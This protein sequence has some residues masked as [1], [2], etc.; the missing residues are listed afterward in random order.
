MS[1]ESAVLAPRNRDD[2][3]EVALPAVLV[4]EGLKFLFPRLPIRFQFTL[5]KTA[6]GTDALL[7]E[8]DSRARGAYR[9]ADAKADHIVQPSWNFLLA[10]TYAE[11]A[12]IAV[13]KRPK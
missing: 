9:A 3:I 10:L 2:D 11:C 1:D 13:I 7:I 4:A 8:D 6:G 5:G 12:A